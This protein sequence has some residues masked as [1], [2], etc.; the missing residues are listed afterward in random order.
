MRQVGRTL[1]AA[2]ESVLVGHRVLI[3][4]A[5]MPSVSLPYVSRA[6]ATDG[7][8][9]QPERHGV[10]GGEVIKRAAG[11]VGSMK[12]HLAVLGRPDKSVRLSMNNSD[13]HTRHRAARRGLWP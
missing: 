9:G 4:F 6:R 3:W 8:V 11:H 5:S 2:D 10:I 13:N 7:V 1:T 12:E